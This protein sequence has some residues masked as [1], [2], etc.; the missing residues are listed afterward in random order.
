MRLRMKCKEQEEKM[1]RQEVELKSTKR[2]AS[3]KGANLTKIS[4]RM[5]AAKEERVASE[6]CNIRVT[7]DHKFDGG[8]IFQG[9]SLFMGKPDEVLSFAQFPSTK[10][11]SEVTLR[12]LNNRASFAVLAL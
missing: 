5:H 1:T 7:K 3:S 4:K 6:N 8:G 9:T 11:N 10:L 2:K 12:H